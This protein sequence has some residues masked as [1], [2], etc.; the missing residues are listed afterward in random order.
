MSN[1]FWS[2]HS[3]SINS[4]YWSIKLSRL[5]QCLSLGNNTPFYRG[6]QWASSSSLFLRVDCA[7]SLFRV[8]LHSL[9]G[10]FA[11]VFVEIKGRNRW[12]K[13]LH[14]SPCSFWHFWNF[15]RESAE[16]YPWW[17]QL[18]IVVKLPVRGLIVFFC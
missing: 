7:P 15:L 18:K 16:F 6:R 10:E 3:H 14:F 4:P 12:E 2:G 9:L 11:R 17:S 1:C 8:P 13:I 5:N